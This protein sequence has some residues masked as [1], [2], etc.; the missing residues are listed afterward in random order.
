MTQKVE[1]YNRYNSLENQDIDSVFEE[2]NWCGK[3][4]T[5]PEYIFTDLDSG[6][7]CCGNCSKVWNLN[8]V[9][10]MDIN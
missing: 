8:A 9:E 6:N 1:S 10:C 7:Y 4:M 5:N 2:C 3:D